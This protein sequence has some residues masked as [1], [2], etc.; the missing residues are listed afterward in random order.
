V[1][2]GV[3]ALAETQAEFG[4]VTPEQAAD[5][6]AHIDEVDVPRALEIEA[7]IYHDLMAELRLFADQARWAAVC[8]TSGRPPRTSK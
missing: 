5:L 8:C 3:V 1:A 7:Q 4:L 2:P 6:K